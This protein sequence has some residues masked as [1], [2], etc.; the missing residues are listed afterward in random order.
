MIPSETEYRERTRALAPLVERQVGETERQRRLPAE[1][2]RALV[3]GKFYRMLLPRSVGGAELPL[4]AFMT[5]IE[6]FARSDASTAW[7][8]AQC[9][10]C[11]MAAAYLEPGTARE[12]FGPDDAIVAWGPPAPS[13]ARIVDGGYRVSG[14]W[15]FASGGHQAG[16]VGAQSFVVDRDGAPVRRPDGAPVIRTMLVPREQ[17]RMADAWHVMGLK[18]TG[19][20]DYEVADVF[21]PERFSFGRDEAADRREEGVLYRFSTSN[22]YALAFAALALGI[23]RRMLD[24]ARAVASAKVPYG[25]KS[26]LRDN[27]VVQAQIGRSE[28][29]WRA[30]R[31]FLYE[32]ARDL[33]RGM[34]ADPTLSLDQRIELRMASVWAIHQAVEIADTVF[35][36]VGSAA[37]FETGPFERRFRDLHTVA[38]QLQ[39]RQSHFESLGQVFLGLEPDAALFTT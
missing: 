34:S 20:D 36:M 32:T 26:P 21:V 2:V 35:R 19:S 5:V 8:V 3:D 33:W 15:K 24:D 17:V 27:N 9:G 6:E 29:G 39:G 1:L 16:W 13:E 37:I 14:K 10:T 30:A 22:V 25:T 38:Q 11:A 7:C 12:V 31:G 18:G 23:A 4:R 28:A